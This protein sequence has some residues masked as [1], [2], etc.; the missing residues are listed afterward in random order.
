V[1]L[2]SAAGVFY[3]IQ[4]RR[5]ERAVGG[6]DPL[7]ARPAETPAARQARISDHFP[8]FRRAAPQRQA[9]RENMLQGNLAETPLHDFLQYLSLGRKAGILELASGRRTGRMVFLEGKIC[10]ASF[11]GKEGLEGAFLMLDLAEGDFEF[12]ESPLNEAARPLEAGQQPLEVVDIIMLW[13]DR[14]PTRKKQPS[15]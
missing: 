11:R 6:D 7:A 4:T 3:F 1:V 12:H 15:R 13:M 10:K 5:R 9:A 8:A 2:L 14:K